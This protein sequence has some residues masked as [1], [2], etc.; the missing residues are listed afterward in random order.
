MPLD[1]G[2]TLKHY[3]QAKKHCSTV[4]PLSFEK[5]NPRNSGCRGA[6]HA[7]SM[8]YEWFDQEKPQHE[9]YLLIEYDTEITMPVKEFYA[10]VWDLPVV[11][12]VIVEAFSNQQI[13]PGRSG[14]QKE[15]GWF[16]IGF[17][18][19]I[20]E[21]AYAKLKPWLRGIVP[22]SGTL[23]SHE[24]LAAM[25]KLFFATPWMTGVFCECR[26]GT[27]AKLSGYEPVSWAPGTSHTNVWCA[28]V[29][30]NKPGVWHRVRS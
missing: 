18:D 4:V 2:V 28:T 25:T 13:V 26:L 5:L 22:V 10:G 9:R 30:P 23:L 16:W 27:L 8:A 19:V 6:Y 20:G 15:W 11:G 29:V 3:D 7:D 14:S 21:A 1:T 24:A 17:K 12:S